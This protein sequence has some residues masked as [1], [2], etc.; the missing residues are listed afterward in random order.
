V[1][2]ALD[3]TGAAVV[4]TGVSLAVGAWVGEAVLRGV[5]A[6][7]SVNLAETVSYA[8]VTLTVGVTAAGAG[9]LQLARNAR[10]IKQI[11]AAN[12]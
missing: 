10:T 5:R 2:V 9:A 1:G 8:W 12:Q 3:C 4:G 11:A 7:A 6:T